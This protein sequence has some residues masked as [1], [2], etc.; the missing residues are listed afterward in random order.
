MIFRHLKIVNLDKMDLE[1]SII[2][3]KIL[4]HKFILYKLNLKLITILIYFKHKNTRMIKD[5]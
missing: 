4:R 3:M 5:R 1:I 2:K